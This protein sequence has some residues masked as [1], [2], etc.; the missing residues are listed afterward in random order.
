MILE[1]RGKKG[2]KIEVFSEGVF[3]CR[4]YPK[5]LRELDFTDISDGQQVE[6]SQDKLLYVEKTLFLPRA[7]RRAL[8]LLE[9][10]EYTEAEL[11]KKLVSDGYPEGIVNAV[12]IYVTELHYVND[13]AFADR[14]ALYLLPKCSERELLQKMYIKG[15]EK[16]LI[17]EAVSAAKETYRFEHEQSETVGSPELVAIQTFLRKKG[18]R[19]EACDNEKRKKLV[20][21]LYRKG[22]SFS[23][24]KEAMGELETEEDIDMQEF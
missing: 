18:Y 5:D 19:P 4:C 8:L 20:A 22:F 21:T 24:I 23:H 11:R 14:Y 15:F 13:R 9:K 2:K 6:C 7:K 12:L 1:L 16:D 17:K 3:Y 10:K